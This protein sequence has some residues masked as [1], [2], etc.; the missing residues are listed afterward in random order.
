[1]ERDT[2]T[3]W[4]FILQVLFLLSYIPITFAAYKWL[5]EPRKLSRAKWELSQLAVEGT[6]EFEEAMQS[7]E[8]SLKQYLVPLTYIFLLLLA[9][10]GLTHPFIIGRGVWKG[11]LE[12]TV[13]IA[14]LPQ[15]AVTADVLF[16]RLLFYT[17]LGA[18]VHSVERTVRHYLLNDLHPDIY[19]S[20]AKRFIVAFIVGAVVIVGIGIVVGVT[21]ADVNRQLTTVYLVAFVVGLFPERGMRWVVTSAAGVLQQRRSTKE[22]RK[23]SEIEGLSYWQRD[24]LE[25]E[26]VENLQNLA[27][28]HLLTLVVRTPYDVGQLVD[29]VD[30]AILLAY[31]SDRQVER[32]QEVGIHRASDLLRAV[33]HNVEELAQTTECDV[34][35]LRILQ[36]ALDS[37]A[38]I[39]SIWRFRFLSSIGLTGEEADNVPGV[40]GHASS[41]EHPST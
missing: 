20:S 39:K 23:L 2:S 13:V 7:T 5:R 22:P 32:M 41:V 18:Y 25:Q 6:P 28:A 4:A 14:L 31:G 3:V 33:Q 21:T 19:V 40:P 27:T 30:Q 38:N 29:W 17:W 12:E 34:E 15:G 16:G 26:G 10:Y 8:Y 9:C 11:L 36:R 1:M 35:E 24:R 37:A